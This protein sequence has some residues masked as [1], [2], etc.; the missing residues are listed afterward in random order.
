[1]ELD[2]T[3]RVGAAAAGKGNGESENEG[4]GGEIGRAHV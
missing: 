4:A 1:M 2:I 3:E